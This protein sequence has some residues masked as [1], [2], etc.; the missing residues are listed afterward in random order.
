M[1]FFYI[2]ASNTLGTWG[3]ALALVFFSF[4]L[5]VFSFLGSGILN[6]YL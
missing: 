6:I 2:W 3:L 4:G 5:L 1:F